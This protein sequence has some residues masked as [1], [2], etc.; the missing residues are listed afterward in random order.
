MVTIVVVPVAVRRPP[1]AGVPMGVL[2][3]LAYQEPEA[4]GGEHGPG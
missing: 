3:L 4:P 1:P 2:V